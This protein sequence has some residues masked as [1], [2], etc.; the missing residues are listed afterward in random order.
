ME[1]SEV[2]IC[3]ISSDG[4]EWA[5][6]LKGKLGE[7]DIVSHLEDLDC[8][9]EHRDRVNVVLATPAM[10]EIQTVK[11]IRT[12]H[13]N[14]SV[15][16]LLGVDKQELNMV[17][18]KLE[19][20]DISYWAFF[21]TQ[22]SDDSVIKLLD[23]IMKKAE[24]LPYDYPPTNQQIPCPTNYPTTTPKLHIATSEHKEVSYINTTVY[25]IYNLI[26]DSKVYRLTLFNGLAT[27]QLF[28]CERT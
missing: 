15:M 12:M 18:E 8:E 11:P 4:K 6:Y 25:D 16:V 23:L 3:Y 7:V 19:Y 2:S 9:Y 14:R 5:K 26:L 13:C 17:F 28:D 27:C 24:I 20:K 1:F 22:Q 21:A 10:L